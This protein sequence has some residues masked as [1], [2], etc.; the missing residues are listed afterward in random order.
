M[1]YQK[2]TANVRVIIIKFGSMQNSYIYLKFHRVGFGVKYNRHFP[3]TYLVN[4]QKMK[5]NKLAR[6]PRE[7]IDRIRSL[8]L[9]QIGFVRLRC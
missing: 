7:N 2:Y 6:Q 9:V 4:R 1:F 3:K 5:V 8:A